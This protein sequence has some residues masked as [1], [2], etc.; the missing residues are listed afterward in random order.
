MMR[1]RGTRRVGIGLIVL[2]TLATGAPAADARRAAPEA[3]ADELSSDERQELADRFRARFAADPRLKDE[4]LIVSVD[5]AGVVRLRGDV[6][7]PPERQSAAQLAGGVRGALCVENDLTIEPAG[8]FTPGGEPSPPGVALPN[9]A[10]EDCW[11]AR[12]IK[13]RLAEL[14]GS[15]THVN[16]RVVSGAVTLEGWVESK[17]TQERALS[18]ARSTRGVRDVEDQLA[19]SDR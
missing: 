1:N 18:V 3:R 14:N 9:A 11:I 12:T 13:S 10:V 6:D 15:K 2:G 4:K 17:T 16:V 7:S 19:V 8:R 5:A